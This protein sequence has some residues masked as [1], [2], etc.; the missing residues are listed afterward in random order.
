MKPIFDINIKKIREENNEKIDNKIK[1]IKNENLTYNEKLIQVLEEEKTTKYEIPL[2]E[3]YHIDI[4]EIQEEWEND[5]QK[6]IEEINNPDLSY[7]QKRIIVLS[8][9]KTK[10]Y[11]IER[12][13][14]ENESDSNDECY[15]PS[16]STNSF[17][18]KTIEKE[19]L[20]D[21][22]ISIKEMKTPKFNIDIGY[23]I[24]QKEKIILEKMR[25]INK[26]NLNDLEKRIETLK[27]ERNTIINLGKY[28]KFDKINILNLY[29]E[30]EKR[31]Q[32]KMK[33]K[34]YKLSE[35]E[36]REEVLKEEKSTEVY[37]KYNPIYNTCNI[38][39]PDI[40]LNNLNEAPNITKL[41]LSKFDNDISLNETA[42]KSKLDLSSL[43]L[44]VN[45]KNLNL[46]KSNNI[47]LNKTLDK[48][49]SFSIDD[50]YLSN[51]N[52]SNYNFIE[53]SNNSFLKN[54]Q[55]EKSFNSIKTKFYIKNKLYDIILLK[56]QSNNIKM[57][58][59][60]KI[61]DSYYCFA[62]PNDLNTYYITESAFLLDQK[63]DYSLYNNI[64]INN[65]IN[66]ELG[67]YFCGNKIKFKTKKGI[68]IE[69]ICRPNEFICKECMEL[70]KGEYFIR[71]D[72][73]ININGRIAKINKEKYHCFGHFLVG[74]LINDC[75][76]KFSCAACKIL[77]SISDYYI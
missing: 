12:E 32:E 75:I 67:L 36:K 63:K 45:N 68:E 19:I 29:D 34:N 23:F 27:S 59:K 24:E 31:I 40:S 7:Y 64:K 9:L 57:A 55:K 73:L 61:N 56:E 13:N 4:K 5:I 42:D 58:E 52:I 33:K 14:K 43:N 60:Y 72:Y 44:E 16:S 74:N 2:N 15:S 50:M 77:D 51:L 28:K 20:Y 70:N 39:E 6:K 66:K 1:D 71:K 21:D 49:D 48:S 35:E 41:N 76:N 22:G 26:S 11:I 18:N 10:T 62:Y 69:K 47:S 46:N 3:K 30:E 54:E 65:N 37:N 53:N 25:K 38:N 8:E 17:S